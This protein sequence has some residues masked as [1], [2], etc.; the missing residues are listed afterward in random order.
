MYRLL[1]EWMTGHAQEMIE[2]EYMQIGKEL[3]DRAVKAYCFQAE[4]AVERSASSRPIAVDSVARR[5]A[6]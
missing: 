6:S 5:I 3:E 2:T 4:C 1:G